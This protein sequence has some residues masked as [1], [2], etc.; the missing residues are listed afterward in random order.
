MRFSEASPNCGAVD[1]CNAFSL[2]MLAARP[3][4]EYRVTVRPMT[5]AEV[6]SYLDWQGQQ[7]YGTRS[8]IG[9]ADTA[10]IVGGMIGVPLEAARRSIQVGCE[11]IIVAQYIGPRLP[12]GTTALPEGARIEFFLVSA[13]EAALPGRGVVTNPFVGEE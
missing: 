3:D 1:I 12:E 2:Q 7:G 8:A 13:Y 11:P 9:H 6:V 4:H 5:L 10:A